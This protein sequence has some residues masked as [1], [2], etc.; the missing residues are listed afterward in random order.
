MKVEDSTTSHLNRIQ[1]VLAVF[2]DFLRTFFTSTIKDFFEPCISPDLIGSCCGML[3]WFD[4]NLYYLLQ[5]EP[6]LL[7]E[8]NHVML[9]HLYALSIKVCICCYF[10]VR[11]PYTTLPPTPQKEWWSWGWKRDVFGQGFM[12]MKIRCYWH[13]VGSWGSHFF[14]DKS[15][16]LEKENFATY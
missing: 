11:H 7:P 10:S 3:Q 9:N 4:R 5:C 6:S 13:G 16:P 1:I 2:I 14:E 15:R 12:C 8:P